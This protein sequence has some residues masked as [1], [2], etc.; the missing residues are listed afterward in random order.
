MLG[1]RTTGDECTEF[2]WAFFLGELLKREI[3]ERGVGWEGCALLEVLL[4]TVF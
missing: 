2:L 1:V 4:L 3:E